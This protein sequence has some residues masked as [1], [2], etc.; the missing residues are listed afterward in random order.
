MTAVVVPPQSRAVHAGSARARATGHP[1]MSGPLSSI[2]PRVEG[3]SKF[4]DHQANGY[5]TH[6]LH[7]VDMDVEGLSNQTEL[8]EMSLLFCVKMTR[9]DFTT[10]HVVMSLWQVNAFLAVMHQHAVQTYQQETKQTSLRGLS[11]IKIV[12]M[13]R[14]N[15][16]LEILKFLSHRLMHEVISLLGVQFGNRYVSARTGPGIAVITSGSAEMRNTCLNDTREPDELWVVLRRRA[17]GAPLAYMLRSYSQRGGPRMSD[18]HYVDLAGVAAWG[19]AVK[20]GLI[21]D[22]ERE[23]IGLERTRLVA[24]GLLGT[25]HDSHYAETNAPPMRVM[26]CTTGLKL[27]QV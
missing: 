21:A 16:R 17:V 12:R 25:T 20:V 9:E 18:R 13:V 2:V 1:V 22:K 15:P 5:T 10:K 27:H 6:N 14:A 4:V 26:L 3:P 8:H 23:D 7:V 19:P 11:E 24:N